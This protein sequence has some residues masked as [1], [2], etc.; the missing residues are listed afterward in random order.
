[1]GAKPKVKIIGGSF[2]GHSKS[3]SLREDNAN[4]SPT[5]FEWTDDYNADVPSV[6]YAGGSIRD[7]NLNQK[8]KNVAILIEPP[9]LHPENYEYVKEHHDKFHAV[10]TYS[11]DLLNAIPNGRFYPLGG[12]SI[13]F[14]DWGLYPKTKDVC[15]IVSEKDTMP[16]HK[17]RHQIVE[18][19]SNQID[20]YGAGVGKPF[21]RKFDILKEYKFCVVVESEDTAL[22]FTEKLFDPISV[23]CFP[24]YNNFFTNNKLRTHLYVQHFENILNLKTELDRSINKTIS[25]PILAHN[26]YNAERYRI[27]EDFIWTNYPELFT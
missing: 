14:E 25:N 10:L 18:S 1:M 11:M 13:A 19:F 26:L 17:L 3:M 6:F 24:I 7:S 5:Y 15:M 9:S 20:F 8:H 2:L 12:S 16:G 23:G 22:Y 27:A 21:D 4:V